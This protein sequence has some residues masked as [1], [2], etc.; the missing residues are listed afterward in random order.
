MIL[1]CT[2]CDSR[3]DVTGHQAGQQF[4]CRCGTVLVL[5]ARLVDG[6][7]SQVGKLTWPHCGAGVARRAKSCDHWASHLLLKATF[8]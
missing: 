6:G 3:Y 4:R 2:G 1:P 7:T 5:D 8:F